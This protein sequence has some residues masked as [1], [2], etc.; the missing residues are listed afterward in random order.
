MSSVL[1]W[2]AAFSWIGAALLAFRGESMG[3]SLRFQ[4]SD[5]NADAKIDLSDAVFTLNYIFRGAA[6]PPCHKA[7]DANDDGSLDISDPIYALV[8]LFGGAAPPPPPFPGCGLDPTEDE[9]PCAAFAPCTDRPLYVNLQIDAELEDTAGLQRIIDEL[10]RRSIPA[11][12]YVTADYAN[13]NAL[14]VRNIFERG[15]EIALH[16]YYTGEQ[17][18][19]MTYAEQLDLLSRAKKALEGCKPCGT[20]KPI[21]G[22]RP[23]YFSQN[24]D[25]YRVLDELGL[26]HN[27]GFKARELSLPGFEWAEAPY[28]APGHGFMAVPLATIVR[29]ESRIYLCDIACAQ[30]L[31]MTAEEWREALLSALAQALESRMPLALLFHNWYTGDTTNYTY[32]QPFVDFLDAAQGKVTFVT[33]DQ[34]CAAYRP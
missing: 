17:L 32:W 24:E 22:F 4:R 33:T 26:T 3:Q 16:G 28:K 13:R 19:S 7:A 11:T 23:Q 18:A 31:Q 10:A 34:L 6:E 12:V 21:V 20:Y 2:T 27:S 5:A 15:F 30:V 1:R 8:F 9:L 25:T 14:L 29:G